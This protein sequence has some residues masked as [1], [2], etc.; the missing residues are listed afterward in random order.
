MARIIFSVSNT[1]I[2]ENVQLTIKSVNDSPI[3]IPNTD[4]LHE[5]YL[6][7]QKY[8]VCLSTTGTIEEVINQ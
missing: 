6:P 8:A 1:S 4:M 5:V 3:T 7:N 2:T